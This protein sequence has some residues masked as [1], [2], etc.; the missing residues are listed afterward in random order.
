MTHRPNAITHT[1]EYRVLA[2]VVRYIKIENTKC[3]RYTFS[4]F[5]LFTKPNLCPPPD[6]K[7]W[8]RH[9]WS[10]HVTA[11]VQTEQTE[12]RCLQHIHDAL[13]RC[14][15]A[16]NQMLSCNAGRMWVTFNTYCT[17]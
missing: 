17:V 13:L 14:S 4:I 2:G 6:T 9:W 10:A 15:L 16:L 7:F 8:R 5:D 11:S 1:R 3:I 12:A